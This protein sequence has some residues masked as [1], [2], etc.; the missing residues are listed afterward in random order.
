MMEIAGVFLVLGFIKRYF[1]TILFFLSL[2]FLLL[3]VYPWY[4]A[5]LVNT[6]EKVLWNKPV[7]IV[8]FDKNIK[9]KFAYTPNVV[10]LSKAKRH[11]WW[12]TLM[13]W[14]IELNNKLWYFQQ[15]KTLYHELYHYNLL[16]IP[17]HNEKI[18][19]DFDDYTYDLNDYIRK[20]KKQFDLI[21]NSQLKDH[22]AYA[23]RKELTD[24]DKY[25]KEHWRD[26]TKRF[27][28]YLNYLTLT[29]LSG[30]YKDEIWKQNPIIEKIIENVNKVTP[31]K[32]TP[33]FNLANETLAFQSTFYYYWLLAKNEP[34][35][36][37]I[38]LYNAQWNKI[39]DKPIK[40]SNIQDNLLNTLC[41]EVNELNK[42]VYKKWKTN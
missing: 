12:K 13:F 26:D 25:E 5:K 24:L 38:I 3:I 21:L 8:T 11:V 2:P 18:V 16:I 32:T 37:G 6:V 22:L 9:E 19:K 35:H 4:N 36:L 20:N 33:K 39:V 41:N 14:A 17:Q 27:R 1:F 28:F 34:L 30:W 7:K 31:I 40:C 15:K 42:Q 23:L 29:V 10:Y